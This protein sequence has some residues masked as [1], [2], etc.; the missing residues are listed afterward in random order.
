[1]IIKDGDPVLIESFSFFLQEL[2]NMV[3]DYIVKTQGKEF[4]DI[5][6]FLFININNT[7]Y[8]IEMILRQNEKNISVEELRKQFD[9]IIKVC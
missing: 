2:D 7:L 3:R 8:C 4:S 5:L 6:E 9:T 1:M